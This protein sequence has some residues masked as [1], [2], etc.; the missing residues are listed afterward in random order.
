LTQI[1]CDRGQPAC[2]RCVGQGLTCVYGVSRKAGKPPRKRSAPDPTPLPI[3]RS[4]K[5]EKQSIDLTGSSYDEL[6]LTFGTV[7]NMAVDN[8][9][10]RSFDAAFDASFSFDSF[11]AL[12]SVSVDTDSA[13]GTTSTPPTS[14]STDAPPSTASHASPAAALTGGR[15]ECTQ[16]CKELMRRLYCA[17]PDTVISDGQA[18]RILDTGSVLER[19]RD[20]MARLSQLLRCPCARS[21][22]MAMLYSSILSRVLLWYRQAV[23]NANPEGDASFL[24]TAATAPKAASDLLPSLPAPAVNGDATMT[25]EATKPAEAR[26]HSIPVSV[27]SFQSDDGQLQ[28]A[29]MNRVMLSE[30]KKVNALIDSFVSL[31]ATGPDSQANQASGTE[32]CPAAAEFSSMAADPGLFQQLGTWLRSEHTQIVWRARRGLCM[33]PETLSF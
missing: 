31:G 25:C 22:H 4:V 12:G 13:L 15:L 1:R 27:G 6:D 28:A 2:V 18:A 14:I 21:P 11:D 8:A 19:N 17:N 29:I 26:V 20:V 9:F 7:E 32:A 3:A 5:P 33:L 10:P 30:L 24:A 16:E 23:W